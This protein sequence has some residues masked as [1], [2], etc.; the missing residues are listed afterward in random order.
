MPTGP[1]SYRSTRVA[2]TRR[3]GGPAPAPNDADDQEAAMSQPTLDRSIG[4]RS[5]VL[6]GLA[7]MAPMIVLATCG[8]IAEETAGAVPSACLRALIALVFTSYRG[9]SRRASCPVAGSSY[10]YVRRT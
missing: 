7:Y 6:F 1:S 8:G 4:L 10:P 2:S 3:G 9:V 5:I